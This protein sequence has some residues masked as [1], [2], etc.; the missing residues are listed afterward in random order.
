MRTVVIRM[1]LAILTARFFIK[2]SMAITWFNGKLN[3]VAIAA[4]EKANA[5]VQKIERLTHLQR[6]E[7]EKLE[8]EKLKLESELGHLHESGNHGS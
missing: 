5:Y 4:N 1:K 7:N 2:T 8:Q 6:F 3:K